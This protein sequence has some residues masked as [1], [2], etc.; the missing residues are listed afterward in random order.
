M[1]KRYTKAKDAAI[2]V[3]QNIQFSNIHEVPKVHP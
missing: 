3:A 1:H 2:I